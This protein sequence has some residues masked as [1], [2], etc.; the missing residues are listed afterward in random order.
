MWMASI[1]SICKRGM[2]LR[3]WDP[4]GL[5]LGF[6]YDLGAKVKSLVNLGIRFQENSLVINHLSLSREYGLG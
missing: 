5:F 1:C 4:I 6:K 3:G 2:L